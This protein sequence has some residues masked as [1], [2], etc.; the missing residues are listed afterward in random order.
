MSH[1]RDARTFSWSWLALLAATAS[2][3]TH[4]LPQG[5]RGKEATA[6]P[7]SPLSR[8]T[9]E[10]GA[11]GAA[12]TAL[13]LARAELGVETA[14]LHALEATRVGDLWAI[15]HEQRW[16][17]LPVLESRVDVL[18]GADG[19]TRDVRAHGLVPRPSAPWFALTSHEARERAREALGGESLAVGPAR[20]VLQ[21]VG[22]ARASGTDVRAAWEIFVDDPTRADGGWRLVIDALDGSELARASLVHC[23]ITGTVSGRGTASGPNES[24]PPAPLALRD[25]TVFGSDG[26]ALASRL[27]SNTF[28]DHTPVISDD[29]S[30]AAFV[31]DADGDAEIWTVATDGTGLLQLTSNTA[32]DRSPSISADG[33]WIAFVSDVDGDPEVFVVRS[34]GTGLTQISSN[35]D[36]DAS[37]SISGSGAL[38]VWSSAAGGDFEIVRSPTSSP[39]T[40]ALTSNAA[41]DARPRLSL[42]GTRIAWVSDLDGDDE[43][44]IMNADGSGALQLT[45]N[46]VPDGAPS[47]RADGGLIAFE[48]LLPKAVASSPGDVPAT[49]VPGRRA[50]PLGPLPRHDDWDVFTI[51]ADGSELTRR[52]SDH[53]DERAPALASDGSAIA[54]QARDGGDGEI[55]VLALG[56]GLEFDVTSDALE[57]SAPS[58]SGNGSRG[59]WSVLDGDLEVAAW[60]T[61]QPGAFLAA[62]TTPTGAFTLPFA[63]GTSASL[64]AR[65]RGPFVRVLDEHPAQSNLRVNASALAPSAGSALVFQPTGA[66]VLRTA[67]VTAFRHVVEAHAKLA[68]ILTRAP[69]ALALPLPIDARLDV[70]VNL[71]DVVAN[72]FYSSLRKDTTFFVGAGLLRPN[73]A[74]DTVL[75]HEYGHHVDDR[76]GGIAGA[77]ACEAAGALSEGAA[78]ALAMLVAGTA[79]I[80]ADWTGPGTYLRHYGIPVAAGGS[81][82][83]QL[84]GKDCVLDGGL[85]E[86]HQ[87]GQAFAGFVDDLRA[88]VGA[89]IAEDL[90][91]GALASNPGDMQGAVS[92]IFA[93]AAGAGYGGS[94]NPATSPLYDVLCAAAARHGFDCYPRPDHASYACLFTHCA[95]RPTHK[96][97][98]TEWLGTLV[99][100][101]SACE[102]LPNPDDDGITFP[103]GVESETWA[104]L[105]ITLR[106]NPAL[107]GSGRYG[108]SIGGAPI[109]QRLVFL[110]AWL[111]VSDLAGGVDEYHVLG[112]G[113]GNPEDGDVDLGFD[114]L[115]YDPQSWGGASTRT[116]SFTIEIPPVAS[117]RPAI[118][119]VRLDYGEDCGKVLPRGCLT[120]TSLDGAC[121]PARF[122]EVEEKQIVI[123]PAGE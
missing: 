64:S 39:V 61:A 8:I 112:T 99:D 54:F 104:P 7:S 49:A 91:L 110:N 47:I 65:L 19:V 68:T 52:T 108:G 4:E 93:L 6:S 55:R 13:D 36:E 33:T 9:D 73:T 78:D 81:R 58:I 85:P 66:D 16:H 25:L 10:N 109:R 89:T 72:A 37:P 32:A 103:M 23:A 83:R 21:P 45:T 18:L 84:D 60:N 74:Y 107:L 38:V 94:G 119:R 62:T 27:T 51:G 70:R 67:Q 116:D 31:S 53:G 63:D 22:P 41:R 86:I 11:R 97:T 1:T 105:S 14:S 30:R 28:A 98:G 77:S 121:G 69:N 75:L 118:L 106:V 101:E 102:P 34:D 113:S 79:V 3:A 44:W 17:D 15:R 92:A 120:S 114:T 115:A 59:V 46:A 111:L 76:F 40:L 100:F 5:P 42:D 24:A 95:I 82:G 122:G 29:G 88:S 117:Q 12:R 50:A 123:V 80:G 71:P 87:H 96:T 35:T 26:A 90:V 48:S 20:A 57:D 56:S 2:A 43:I